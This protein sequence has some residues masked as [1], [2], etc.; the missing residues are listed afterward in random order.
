[1]TESDTRE[2]ERMQ[3]DAETG[4]QDVDDITVSLKPDELQL[5]DAWIA[6][7]DPSLTRTSAVKKILGLVAMRMPH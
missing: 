2:L 5:L 4:R 6:A 3:A 1:M 7:N